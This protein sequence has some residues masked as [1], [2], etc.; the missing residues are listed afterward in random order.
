MKQTKNEPKSCNIRD[1]KYEENEEI[2][3][4][5]EKKKEKK[6][7]WDIENMQTNKKQLEMVLNCLKWSWQTECVLVFQNTI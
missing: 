6:K 4:K 7:Q 1:E 5:Y 2:K 3:Q